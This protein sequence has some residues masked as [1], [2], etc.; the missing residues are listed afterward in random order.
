M[1][2]LNIAVMSELANAVICNKVFWYLASRYGTFFLQFLASIWLAVK[3]GPYYFGLWSFILLLVNI[4][5]QCNWGVANAANILLV[6]NKD[7]QARRSNIEVTSLLMTLAACL[8]PFVVAA[9]DAIHPIPLFAKYQLGRMSV[10]VA[11]II[12]G[13]YIN[14]LF[15][16]IFRVRNKLLE[17]AFSQSLFPVLTLVVILCSSGRTLLVLLVS[18]YLLSTFASMVA[19]LRARIISWHGRFSVELLGT[20]ASKGFYLFLYNACF[21]LIMLSTKM[22]VSACYPVETFG[23]FAF[24]FNVSNATVLLIDSLMFLLFPKMIDVL[25]GQDVK[26]IAERLVSMRECYIFAMSVL[27]FTMIAV[28]GLLIRL[29]PQYAPS[30]SM[31]VSISLTMLVYSLCF[32]HAVYLLAQNMERRMAAFSFLALLLNVVGVWFAARFLKV[33]VACSLAG[34]SIAYGVYVLLVN[35]CSLHRLGRSNNVHAASIMMFRVIVPTL[36]L[37][38]IIRMNWIGLIWLPLVLV[39]LLDMGGFRKVMHFAI[40][41]LKNPKIMNV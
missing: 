5:S 6:Q 29:L 3:L 14:L 2:R 12:A 18:C 32:G 20:I 24:A 17:I 16:N 26:T 13:Y 22:I 41:L 1:P 39:L 34:T 37:M 36:A 7:D 10:A 21:Y 25:K 35:R 31:L 8:L 19:F 28:F 33:S 30:F 38:A 9:W 15:I 40:R 4:G 23:H 27:I 11:F